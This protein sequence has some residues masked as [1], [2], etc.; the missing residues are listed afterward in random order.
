[1]ALTTLQEN[2]DFLGISYLSFTITSANDNL[3][4]AYDGGTITSVDVPDGTYSGDNLA[5]AMK[6]AI[7][8]ALSCTSTVTWSSTTY[9]FTIAVA[10]G[11][12]ISYTHASSELGITVGFDEDHAAALSITSDNPISDPTAIV[13]TIKN[14]VEAWLQNVYCRRNFESTAYKEYYDGRG[15]SNY[16]DGFVNNSGIGSYY[17]LDNTNK[18]IVLDNYPIIS[19]NRLSVGTESVIK[20]TNTNTGAHASVSCSS[21]T[22]TLWKDG[23]TNTLSLATYTTMTTLVDAINLLSG[24]SAGLMS[25][26]YGS[27]PSTILSEKMGMSC[28]NNYWVYLEMPDEGWSGFE[29]YP[30]E[31][32]IYSSSGFPY[33][34]KNVFVDYTAGYE[35]VP[36]DLKLAVMILVKYIYQRRNEESFGV[37]SYSIAGI[38]Q[39]FSGTVPDQVK[40]IVDSKY[41]RYIL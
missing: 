21:T 13:S 8:T 9:K 30:T 31:G 3:R 4:L 15:S 41:R 6:T 39:T 27:Y 14:S 35:V 16:N 32:K 26:T 18:V 38:S 10:A 11:H 40:N 37:S 19:L 33:G 22:V 29:V 24:W 28:I 7:D 23:T 25:S 2:L 17:G 12:T 36:E 1:M 34:H 5:T 20:V